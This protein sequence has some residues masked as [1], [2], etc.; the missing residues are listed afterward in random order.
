MASSSA[1]PALSDVNTTAAR[2]H[3]ARMV[4]GSPITSSLSGT[5]YSP[6]SAARSS[7]DASANRTSV[8]V[9]SASSRTDALPDPGSISPAPVIAEQV[10]GGNEKDGCR[11]RC[12]IQATR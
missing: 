1:S 10:P 8:R 2:P 3:P 7:L 5:R 12:G 4:S 9:T 11:H 6:R